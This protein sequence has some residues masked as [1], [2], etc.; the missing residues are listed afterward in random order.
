LST[1]MSIVRVQTLTTLSKWVVNSVGHIPK[2]KL[3]VAV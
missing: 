2:D 1:L 3:S